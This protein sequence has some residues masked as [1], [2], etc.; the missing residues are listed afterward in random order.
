MFKIEAFNVEAVK[1]PFGILA[2][3]RYEFR[4]ELDVEDDDEL[5]LEEGVCLRVIYALAEE[6]SRIVKYEFLN[7]KTN[8]YIAFD[9]E[10]DEAQMVERFC[11][12]QLQPGAETSDN[13]QQ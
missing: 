4:L 11:K 9:M 6:N 2:G 3:E 12:E 1:D 5:Y 10:K 7:K 13:S 8:Q